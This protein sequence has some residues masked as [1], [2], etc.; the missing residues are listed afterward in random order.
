MPQINLIYFSGSI[1]WIGIT[2][3]SGNGKFYIKIFSIKNS[4]IISSPYE[5]QSFKLTI[6]PGQLYHSLHQQQPPLDQ[7]ASATLDLACDLNTNDKNVRYDG[8]F[9]VSLVSMK[10]ITTCATLANSPNSYLAKAVPEFD[11]QIIISLRIVVEQKSK[12]HN[13]LSK[14]IKKFTNMDWNFS[15]T[16][17]D[18]EV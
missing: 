2:K 3:Y 15:I 5:S 11:T 7:L 18:N 16:V 14:S 8:D 13:K 6:S 10:I 1:V 17:P 9:S 12:K 4:F